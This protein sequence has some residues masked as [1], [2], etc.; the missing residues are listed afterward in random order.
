MK[1]L[2]IAAALSMMSLTANAGVDPLD[3]IGDRCAPGDVLYYGQNLKHTKEVLVCQWNTNIF[4]SFGKVGQKP[5]LEFKLDVSQVRQ[6]IIDDKTQSSE[7][8][9]MKYKTIVY[10]VASETKFKTGE[11]VNH[12]L[13]TN[14]NGKLMADI[15]LDD[16]TVVNGIRNNFVK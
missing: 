11:T 10:T 16:L 5:E 7:F 15:I 3:I 13:V 2:I 14:M 1:K 8:L 6:P 12:L 9:A 4:Y